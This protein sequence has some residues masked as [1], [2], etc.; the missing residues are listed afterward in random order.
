MHITSTIN[1][2]TQSID[3][4]PVI[5]VNLEGKTKFLPRPEKYEELDRL[6]RDYYT[7]DTRAG[8]HFEVCSWDVC[9]GQNVEVTEAAYP[10]LAPLLDSV[11]VVVVQDGRARVMPTPSATP[12]LRG[13]DEIEDEQAVR[14]HLA[15]S[16]SSHGRATESPPCRVPKV[17]SEDEEVFV[18]SRYGDDDG[19][20]SVHVDDDDGDDDEEAE[21]EDAPHARQVLNQEFPSERKQAKRKVVRDEE[22]DAPQP[23]VA[24]QEFPSERTSSKTKAPPKPRAESSKAPTAKSRGAASRSDDTAESSH[25]DADER[26]K[27]YVSGPRPEHRAEFMT[28]GGHLVKKVLSGVCR[29]FDLDMAHAKLMLC[30]Q[31]PNEHGENEVVQFECANDDTVARSGIKPNA[32]LIVRVEREVY[33]DEEEED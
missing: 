16:E 19:D 8:L 2:R 13:D 25:V 5:L 21:E 18:G 22:E 1:S 9:A 11:S 31:L 24:K 28:R 26:F 23:R 14:D 17:E 33:D 32:K 30:M 4:I 7:V 12:P 27:V 6:V 15:E 3:D 29:T 10:F 20:R